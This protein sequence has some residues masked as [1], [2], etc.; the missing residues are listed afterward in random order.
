VAQN[1][2]AGEARVPIYG[3]CSSGVT[4]FGVDCQTLTRDEGCN[5]DFFQKKK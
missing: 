1:Q 4:E 2:G 5:V 3:L